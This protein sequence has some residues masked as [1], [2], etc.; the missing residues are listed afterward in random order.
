MLFYYILQSW[1]GKKCKANYTKNAKLTMH[2]VECT[3]ASTNIKNLYDNTD[4]IDGVS[5]V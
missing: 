5:E 2:K 4:Y 3:N 1:L